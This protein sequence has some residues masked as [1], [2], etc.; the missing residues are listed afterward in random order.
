MNHGRKYQHR[1]P[2]FHLLLRLVRTDPESLFCKY[3]GQI[4]AY[5]K[6]TC[7]IVDE[8]NH[9][10]GISVL[11]LHVREVIWVRK[12]SGDI[13][14]RSRVFVL[15]LKEYNW[16][17]ICYLSFGNS[18]ADAGYIIVGCR[19]V[20]WRCSPQLALDTLKPARETSS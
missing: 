19:E 3:W 8:G 14:L 9:N 5:P 18:C 15:W 7:V 10:P 20:V 12:P 4:F 11:F 13:S 6:L 1:Q 17:S 16:A 2:S